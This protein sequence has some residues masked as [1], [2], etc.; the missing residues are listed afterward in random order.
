MISIISAAT[1]RALEE[2]V[3]TA[4]RVPGLEGELAEQRRKTAEAQSVSS[5]LQQSLDERDRTID[6]L[7]AQV[8]A[9]REAAVHAAERMAAAPS[10]AAAGHGSAHA[11]ITH[12]EPFGLTDSANGRKALD[13]LHKRT[14]PRKVTLLY[15]YGQ[16][17]SAHATLE[18]A[19]ATAHRQGASPDGWVAST[20]QSTR[21][22]DAPWTTT[23]L[24]V[25]STAPW[26]TPLEPLTSVYIVVSA[27]RPYAAFSD[28]DDAIREQGRWGI[29]HTAGSLIRVE[30]VADH[31][32]AAA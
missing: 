18:A 2:A 16:L 29:A 12:A 3:Q 31:A 1:R 4:Q 19:Q 23:T 20:R 11:F 13:V 7:K 9:L 30:L 14:E 28:Q 25:D 26:T 15:R 32:T 10:H 22:H 6:D 8:A 17:T 24:E 5:G 27:G 21:E